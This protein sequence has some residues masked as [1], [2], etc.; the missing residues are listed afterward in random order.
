VDIFCNRRLSTD[1]RQVDATVE[2]HCNGGVTTTDWM[3]RL[4]GYNKLVWLCESGKCNILSQARFEEEYRVIYDSDN[5]KGFIVTHRKKGRSRHFYQLR[6]GLHYSDFRQKPVINNVFAMTTMKKQKEQFSSRDVKRATVA[7]KLQNSTGNMSLKDFL[8]AVEN[9][10][11]KNCPG[12]PSYIKLAE[13]IYGPSIPC[14]RGKTTRNAPNQFRIETT[15]LPIS[16][17]EKCIDVTIAAD[18]MFVRGI[19]FFVTI[20]EHIKFGSGE[21]IENAKVSTLAEAITRVCNVYRTRGFRVNIALMDGQFEPLKGHMP[22]GVMLNMVSAEEHAGLIE[23]YIRVF[24]ERVRCIICVLLFK[25]YPYV[26][27]KEI[28]NGAIFWLNVFNLQGGG[29]STTMSPRTIVLGTQI[30]YKRHCQVECGQYVETHDP[31]DNSMIPRSNP[32]LFLR[33]NGNAQGGAFFMSLR[34][35]KRIN[36]QAWTVLPMPDYVPNQVKDL[37]KT[38]IEGLPILNW[39]SLLKVL[40]TMIVIII[41][42]QE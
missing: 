41:T 26:M 24:K 27:V 28:V 42:A 37:A 34:T 17:H 25:Y 20:P 30:D 39:R 4:P 40:V 32:A 22:K 31:H 8:H 15:P 5:G 1:I 3:L 13:I 10:N 9:N 23:R 33:P 14:L 35:G 16:V 21:N 7:R 18:I 6:K 19:C 12:T 38:N 2:V 36:R 29:I 11:I